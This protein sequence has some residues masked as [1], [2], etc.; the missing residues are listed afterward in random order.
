MD[1]LRP[2]NVAG[3]SDTVYSTQVTL[4]DS[5]EGYGGGAGSIDFGID[6]LT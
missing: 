4:G 1:E 3:L 6:L 2:V 5:F